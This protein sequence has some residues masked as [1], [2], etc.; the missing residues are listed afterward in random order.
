MH[1][2]EFSQLAKEHQSIRSF[3]SD[4]IPREQIEKFIETGLRS[5]T[6][7]NL[8]AWS[9]VATHSKEIKKKL[10]KAHLEQKMILDAP[11]VL[12]FCSDFNRVRK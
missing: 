6:F 11:Y 10:H 8:Q 3:K 9:V 1:F 5:S 2:S 12:T 7:G 4:D